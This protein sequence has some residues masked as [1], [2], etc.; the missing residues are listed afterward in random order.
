MAKT[1]ISSS[2]FKGIF[3]LFGHLDKIWP[4]SC[5]KNE[6]DTSYLFDMSIKMTKAELKLILKR[7]QISTYSYF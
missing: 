1:S 4:F 2:K 7:T 6:I 3:F 5:F